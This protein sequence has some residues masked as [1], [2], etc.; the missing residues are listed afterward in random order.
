[1]PIDMAAEKIKAGEPYIIRFKSPGNPEKK[2]KHKD[3]IK[4]NIDLPENDQDVVIIKSD[5]LPTFHFAHA[6]DDHLMGVNLVNR[7]DEWIP[8]HTHLP[9]PQRGQ[10]SLQ[11]DAR[12]GTRRSHRPDP[13]GFEQARTLHQCRRCRT[14]HRQPRHGSR[15]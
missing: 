3:A 15:A 2:I 13:D 8:S 12:D 10:H 6:V 4:G 14:R 7:S 11:D 5:G 9:Q 1:M